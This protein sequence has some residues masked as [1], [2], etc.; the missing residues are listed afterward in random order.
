MSRRGW[1]LDKNN[2]PPYQN[3][4]DRIPTK[5]IENGIEYIKVYLYDI[6]IISALYTKK[7][8]NKK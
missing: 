1:S 6:K 7:I 4:Q 3:I 5:I 8:K 2:V